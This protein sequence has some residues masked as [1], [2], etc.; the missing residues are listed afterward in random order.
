MGAAVVTYLT[1]KLAFKFLY[2]GRGLDSPMGRGRVCSAFVNG[3]NIL[4]R[5]RNSQHAEQ[6][7]WE[8]PLCLL[9]G[10]GVV[11]ILVR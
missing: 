7:V 11:H 10:E 3:L 2:I 5:G 4:K 6:E 8:P 1:T 9:E